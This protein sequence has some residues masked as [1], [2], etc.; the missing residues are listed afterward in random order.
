MDL[1]KNPQAVLDV[2]EFYTEN[3]ISKNDDF[4]GKSLQAHK[5]LADDDDYYST[6]LDSQINDL[7]LGTS[8]NVSNTP[9]GLKQDSQ[10]SLREYTP[11]KSNRLEDSRTNLDSKPNYSQNKEDLRYRE[12]YNRKGDSQTRLEESSRFKNDAM[13]RPRDDFQSRVKND[14]LPRTPPSPSARLKTKLDESRT[15]NTLM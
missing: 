13:E 15:V 1:S 7:R 9:M 11:Q 5:I 3:L 12:D 8:Q 14:A 4:Q 6:S 2:L 10:S